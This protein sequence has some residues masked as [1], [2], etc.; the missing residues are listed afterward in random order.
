VLAHLVNIHEQV[1][2]H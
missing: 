1:D 2:Q